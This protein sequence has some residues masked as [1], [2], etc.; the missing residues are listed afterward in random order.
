MNYTIKYEYDREVKCSWFED[1]ER[2]AQFLADTYGTAE[3]TDGTYTWVF[4][5]DGNEMI[6]KHENTIQKLEG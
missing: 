4:N 6:L 3:L 5:K 2:I 1:A